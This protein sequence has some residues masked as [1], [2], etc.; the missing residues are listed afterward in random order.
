[1]SFCWFRRS[2]GNKC[3]ATS[4]LPHLI[5]HHHV[6]SVSPATYNA[7]SVDRSARATQP[8]E[9]SDGFG[10]RRYGYKQPIVPPA[11]RRSFHRLEIPEV[12]HVFGAQQHGILLV[13][14]FTRHALSHSPTGTADGAVIL[15]LTFGAS[16]A[17]FKDQFTS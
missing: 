3:E 14:I 7:R 16:T 15:V 10:Q 4:Y 8:S 9:Q 12:S 1:V 13:R 6:D 2:V 5:S 11:F 17:R